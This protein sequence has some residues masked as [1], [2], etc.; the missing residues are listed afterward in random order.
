MDY[1][2]SKL[3]DH[4]SDRANIYGDDDQQTVLIQW[5]TNKLELMTIKDLHHIENLIQGMMYQENLITANFEEETN[6][7]D[8]DLIN[9]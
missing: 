3:E 4:Q 7:G 1:F 9:Y 6:F 8:L 2:N 5:I